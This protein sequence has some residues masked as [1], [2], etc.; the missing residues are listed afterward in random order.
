MNIERLS[1]QLNNVIPDEDEMLTPFVMA[2]KNKALSSAFANYTFSAMEQFMLA[3]DMLY[4]GTITANGWYLG[5]PA[6]RLKK[7]KVKEQKR[8]KEQFRKNKTAELCYIFRR[9]YALDPEHEKLWVF[10]I[11]IMDPLTQNVDYKDNENKCNNHMALCCMKGNIMTFH[12]PLGPRSPVRSVTR[13]IANI[14]YD[15]AL[16]E[17]SE[18]QLRMYP[19]N[20]KVQNKN[21]HT[22]VLWCG[23]IAFHLCVETNFEEVNENSQEELEEDLIQFVQLLTLTNLQVVLSLQSLQP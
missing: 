23:W 19:H 5:R 3:D 11:N 22:C 20:L 12:D 10:L 15:L 14:L 17:N 4:G 2:D 13:A 7:M 16:K 21:T 8:T 6:K 1:Y 18:T 9:L